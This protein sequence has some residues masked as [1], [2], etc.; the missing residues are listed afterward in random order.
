ML[1]TNQVKPHQSEYWR[2]PKERE[3]P[4]MHRIEDVMRIYK[5]PYGKNLPVVCLDEK[6]L[7]L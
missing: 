6:L 1:G 7:A 5:K 4:L 3:P 2:T